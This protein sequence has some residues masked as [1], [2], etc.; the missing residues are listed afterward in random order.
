[1][2]MRTYWMLTLTALTAAIVSAQEVP[3]DYGVAS[4]IVRGMVSEDVGRSI[5]A[6][7]NLMA[8]Y[9]N[10]ALE[11]ELAQEAARRGLTERIDVRRTLEDQRRNTLI[12]ALRNEITRTATPPDDA[13]LAAEF[14]K[15]QDKLVM[16]TAQKLDVYSISAGQ[17]QVVERARALAESGAD[18]TATLTNRGFVH[19]T[20]QIDEPWFT[21]NQV[22]PAIWSDLLA[23]APGDVEV[24]P[25]GGTLLLIRK[26]EDREARPMTLEEATPLLRN[27]LM[28]DAQMTLWN[29]YVAEKASGLGF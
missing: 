16:P 14:K 15:Q 24:F 9:R 29:N 2:H 20:G 3:M 27:A 5:V 13:T 28:R 10:I 8:N 7:T 4:E 26:L 11:Q 12:L 19:V 23:M 18:L 1:M 21:A 17:T 25:D 6:S 22:A